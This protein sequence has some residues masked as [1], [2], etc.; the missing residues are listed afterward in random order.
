MREKKMPSLALALTPVLAMLLLMGVGSIWLGLPAEPM[1][2][3]A[4]VVGGVIAI[5]LGY[6]YDEIMRT[7]AEKIAKVMPALLIL[8]TVGLMI[9]AWMAGGTIPMLIYYGLEIVSPQ[10]LYIT[11]LVVTSVVAICTGTSWG[12][13]GTIGVAF[14]GVAL[15]MDGVNLGIV[16]GA[17]VSG[18]YFGDKLS[19]L[20]DTTNLAAAVTR[21]PL[22]THIRHLL[23]TTVPSWLTAAV[24]MLIAGLGIDAGGASGSEKVAAIN[25]ALSSG[26]SWNILLLLP[27]L[28]VLFG[29]MKKLP[30]IPVMLTASAVAMINAVAFQ[31]IS[32]A[33]TFT[34][35]VSGFNLEMLGSGFDAGA[36]IDDVG[37]LL[38]RGG[39][40]GMMGTLLIAFC[41][42]T[43]AGVIAVTRS[44]DLIVE[45]LLTLAKSTG[46]V[47]LTTIA[48][49]LLT[50][51][52]TCN[53]Q[54]SILMPS[55]L[56][57]EAY[58]RRGLHPKN[59][60]RTV[61][62][63]ATIIEPILPWTAAGAYMA[64]TLGV[65]T[66][67]YLPWAT[68]CWTGIIFAT[69]WGFTGFGIAKLTPEEQAEMLAEIEQ[70][71]ATATAP[72]PAA[73]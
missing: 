66:M 72:A 71:K 28:I 13:V 63:S 32:I 42:I 14:M 53:G 34:S 52:T 46:S 5:Y 11:A 20:S 55:E 51:G 36:A 23:Y 70:E 56:M 33:D 35:L 38:N 50:I 64:A 43:F 27:V 65:A 7:V 68:L 8:V 2:I 16:A 15:G 62:D 22:Y 69:I 1:V 9:G 6:T 17:V 48:V 60:G 67:T 26:F 41:A 29:S 73:A 40:S 49:G 47:I 61:E 24:V 45:K 30:T 37:T 57:R 58:I 31:K 19:P 59:L 54:I 44:L 39:M 3:I 4:A 25:G 21:V 10:Y 18:A 12:S